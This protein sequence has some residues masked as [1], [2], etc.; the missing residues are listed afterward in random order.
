MANVA[1]KPAFCFFPIFLHDFQYS[2]FVRESQSISGTELQLDD[3][4]EPDTPYKK[5]VEVIVQE[6]LFDGIAHL[7]P[8]FSFKYC[9]K[10]VVFSSVVLCLAFC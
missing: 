9:C 5:S 4:K 2:A 10:C 1:L 3:S 8:Y 6:P 7:K